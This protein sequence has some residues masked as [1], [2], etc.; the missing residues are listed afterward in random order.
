MGSSE[1][2]LALR[3]A[4]V[5][6]GVVSFALECLGPEQSDASKHENPVITANIFSIWTFGWM[7]PLMEKGALEYITEND[8][9]NLRPK[10]AATKL[11][12][13]LKKALDK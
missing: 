10:D 9:P 13:D 5:A 12:D 4:V 3:C 2:L 11:G 6:L 7:T 8:L 1:V